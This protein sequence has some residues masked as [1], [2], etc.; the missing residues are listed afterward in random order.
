MSK[1]FT[2]NASRNS[3]PRTAASSLLVAILVLVAGTGGQ[4]ADSSQLNW[5]PNRD[6]AIIINGVPSAMLP[7]DSALSRSLQAQRPRSLS[8]P[9]PVRSQTFLSNAQIPTETLPTIVGTPQGPD[10]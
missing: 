10:G 8:R 3:P 2:M 6:D 7:Q 9:A 1:G 5:A 4:A